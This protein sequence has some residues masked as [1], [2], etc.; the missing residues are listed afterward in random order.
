MR[1]EAVIPYPPDGSNKVVESIGKPLV[2]RM[3]KDAG[4]QIR[5]LRESDVGAFLSQF[6][7]QDDHGL[8]DLGRVRFGTFH[9]CDLSP[10]RSVTAT[11]ERPCRERLH[12]K[13]TAMRRRNREPRARR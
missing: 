12:R 6:G 8:S 10:R 4:V 11:R 2:D 3:L 9:V 7:R 13:S 5:L 1:R